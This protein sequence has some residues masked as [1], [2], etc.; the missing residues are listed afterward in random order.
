MDLTAAPETP[1]HAFCW[2]GLPDV[3][4]RQLHAPLRSQQRQQHLDSLVRLHPDIESHTVGERSL[5]DS[6]LVAGSERGRLRQLDQTA[7]LTLS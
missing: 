3:R 6:D 2:S 1:T 4:F 7:Y 5:G